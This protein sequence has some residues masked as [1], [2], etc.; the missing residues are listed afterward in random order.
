MCYESCNFTLGSSV[1]KIDHLMISLDIFV[2]PLFRIAELF[3]T[4]RYEQT[5]T[6]PVLYAC[7]SEAALSYEIGQCLSSL[8]MVAYRKVDCI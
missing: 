1:Q 5:E 8:F 3:F 7:L 2:S 6:I 4:D